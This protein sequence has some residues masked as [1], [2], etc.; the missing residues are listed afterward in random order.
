MASRRLEWEGARNVRDLGGLP[1]VRGG[2]TRRGAVVRSGSLD[3]L[4]PA[5]CAAAGRHGIRTVVDVRND[6][7]FPPDATP[8]HRDDPRAARRRRTTGSPDS[9]ARSWTRRDRA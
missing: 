9:A 8:L 6:D 7:E 1:T 5:S 3:A 4:T 2:V